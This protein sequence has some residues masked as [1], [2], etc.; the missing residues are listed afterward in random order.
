MFKGMGPDT[1]IEVTETGGKHSKIPY[2]FDLIDAETMFAVAEVLAAGAEKYGENNW[3]SI[4]VEAN[5]NHLLAHVFAY[6]GGDDQDDHLSHVC[7]RAIF[8]FST[9]MARQRKEQWA[10]DQPSRDAE[11]AAA[12]AD[13]DDAQKRGTTL[14][15][16][17][18]NPFL[19]G[20]P[21]TDEEREQRLQEELEKEAEAIKAHLGI[22][23]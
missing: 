5:L 11:E 9:H 21:P 12:E 1:E 15:G 18:G 20:P 4:P 17:P 23:A 16:L 8:A 7:C 2:R 22:Q 10:A 6:L 14:L 13:P 19:P 3:R